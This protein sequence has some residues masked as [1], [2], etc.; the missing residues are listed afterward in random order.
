MIRIKDFT[1]KKRNSFASV[2]RLQRRLVNQIGQIGTNHA[3]GQS[4]QCIDIQV[5]LSLYNF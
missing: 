5:F 3:G 4:G 2:Y 1:W